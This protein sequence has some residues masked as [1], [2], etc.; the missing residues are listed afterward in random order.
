MAIDAQRDAKPLVLLVDDCPEQR[1]LYE[2]VLGDMLTI[3][4]ASH[5]E[6]GLRTA[7]ARAVDCIVL[8]VIMPGIDGWEVCR[9]LKADP[10]TRSIPVIM[11]TGTDADEAPARTIQSGAAALLT[12]PCSA[13]RL[14]A[15]ILA[16]LER[17][18]A[19]KPD[20]AS[21]LAFE[22]AIAA[23]PRG[24]ILVVDDVPST[25]ALLGGV[26]E[27]DGHTV[28]TARNGVEALEMIAKDEPDLVLLDVVMPLMN[29]FETCQAIKR[30]AATRLTPVVL[31]TSMQEVDAKIK[32][33]ESGA[34]DFLTRPVHP[35]ELQARVRSLLRLRQHISDLDSADA[36]IRSLALT[37]EAR[38]GYTN[39]HCQRL[40]VYAA[41][42]G[43]E[44]GLD[45]ADLAAL[46]AGGYL[47]DIGKVGVPD[48]ILLKRGALSGEE[49]DVMKRHTV[50]GDRLCGELRVL[51]RVRPIVR[52]HH[53]RL[54]GSGYP[55]GRAGDDI[56]LLAQIISV[57]D[58]FDALTTDRPYRTATTPEVACNTLKDEV[59][60]CWK[61]ADLVEAFTSLVRSGRLAVPMAPATT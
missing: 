41:A 48:S 46:E 36:V 31:V 18:E 52:H 47:H 7:R 58:V 10:I 44:L 16:C 55:D 59:E 11:L 50:I 30:R 28:T 2:F 6:E 49:A 21:I 42:L 15:T 39:G 14:L 61:R 33:L 5:G 40:A 9:R 25:R 20:A 1:D 29:G 17:A 24:R 35:P 12:K 19:P 4:S 45:A 51:T 60:R 3:V 56:P 22:A 57:V 54:D 38:D 37:I 13:S 27:N 53:E 26:L 34:D 43:R 23:P 8:D 32:G